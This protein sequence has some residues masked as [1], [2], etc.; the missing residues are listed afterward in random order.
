MLPK[1]EWIDYSHRMIHHGRAICI[2][3]RPKCTDCGL[4]SVCER[5]GL[6][7][8]GEMTTKS[9]ASPK[10]KAAAA[11]SGAKASRKKK[12]AS[13]KSDKRASKRKSPNR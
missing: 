3:R 13:K 5:V 10:K 6:P 11:K 4:L 1:K 2:A 9:K 7:E 8:V 12:K